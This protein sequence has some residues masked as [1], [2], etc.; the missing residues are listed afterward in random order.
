MTN[1]K[2][3]DY[4]DKQEGYGELSPSEGSS[5]ITQDCLLQPLGPIPD[6][7]V[8]GPVQEDQDYYDLGVREYG[9][10]RSGLQIQINSFLGG[11]LQQS[12]QKSI[13]VCPTVC[14]NVLGHAE[15]YY[16]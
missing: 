1:E 6:L 7:S 4:S 13:T 10:R 9:D 5:L 2:N 16:T 15:Q 3:N 14:S 12:I 11:N 8:D